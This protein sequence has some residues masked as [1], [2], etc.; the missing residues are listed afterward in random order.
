MLS[1]NDVYKARFSVGKRQKNPR[2]I[3]RGLVFMLQ[4][5]APYC[6]DLSLASCSG[7]I[8]QKGVPSL[9]NRT[10]NSK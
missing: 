9:V 7:D 4:R 8:V 3:G 1:R 2:C 6:D 10:L 5:I